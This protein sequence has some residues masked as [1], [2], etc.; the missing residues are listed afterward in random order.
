MLFYPNSGRKLTSQG[1]RDMDRI[2]GQVNNCYCVMLFAANDLITQLTAYN[3]HI[4]L[5]IHTVSVLEIVVRH[6][7]Y[8]DQKC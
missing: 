1:Q 2:A 7:T 4:L 3:V 6:Q 8:F 5:Y